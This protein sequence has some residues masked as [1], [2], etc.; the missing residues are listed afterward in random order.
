MATIVMWC[1][2]CIFVKLLELD[3][4]GSQHVASKQTSVILV[5]CLS[6]FIVI[7]CVSRY[8]RRFYSDS[9]ETCTW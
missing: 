1:F 9:D 2:V 3:L 8:S 4:C 6:C 5:K 7:C